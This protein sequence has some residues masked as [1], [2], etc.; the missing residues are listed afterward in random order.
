M[1]KVVR[2][3]D[4]ITVKLNDF[5]KYT[6]EVEKKGW[7][8]EQTDC[9]LYKKMKMTSFSFFATGDKEPKGSFFWIFPDC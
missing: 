3:N 5:C 7:H 6:R 4:I 2:A 9:D 1:I 8:L